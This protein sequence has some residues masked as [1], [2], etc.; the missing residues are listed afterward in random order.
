M[1]NFQ[2]SW[3]TSSHQKHIQI[4]FIFLRFFS[5]FLQLSKFINFLS[6]LQ[7]NISKNYEFTQFLY[8]QQIKIIQLSN[9]R[10]KIE[11]LN[12]CLSELFSHNPTQIIVVQSFMKKS[13]VFQAKK[14]LDPTYS[15]KSFSGQIYIENK[16][17]SKWT[18]QRRQKQIERN[19]DLIIIQLYIQKQT[20]GSS[21]N[22]VIKY[23][24]FGCNQSITLLSKM[25][26]T[27]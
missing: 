14:N 24:Q 10:E 8:Y 2:S 27:K 6:F 20:R 4:L 5:N 22:K 12:M 25:Q 7:E 13:I 9:A 18:N 23:S 3:L 11:N 26:E 16:E 21:C 15:I 19:N 1:R 17:E